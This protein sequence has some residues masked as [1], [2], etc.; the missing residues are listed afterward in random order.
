MRARVASSTLRDSFRSPTLVLA[1]L[2][3]KFSAQAPEA[4]LVMKSRRDPRIGLT[5]CGVTE[6]QSDHSARWQ[7]SGEGA[8]PGSSRRANY[9]QSAPGQPQNQ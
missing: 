2:S 3:K 5:P 1:I 9:G 7:D 8:D 6:G 4:W